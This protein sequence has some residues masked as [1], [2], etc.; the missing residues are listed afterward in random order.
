MRVG[1]RW[2]RAGDRQL[3]KDQ[4]GREEGRERRHEK[5]VVDAESIR[6]EETSR[7]RWRKEQEGKVTEEEEGNGDTEEQGRGKRGQ[8]SPGR[9][10]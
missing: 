4:W 6:E 7:K 10:R 3:Y 8:R 5:E 1:E 9:K 2:M